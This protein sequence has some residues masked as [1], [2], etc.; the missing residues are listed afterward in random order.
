MPYRR[1]GGLFGTR[2]RRSTR[3]EEIH[4]SSERGTR[5]RARRVAL[6]RPGPKLEIGPAA[7]RAGGEAA[8]GGTAAAA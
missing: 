1:R 4:L 2:R 6:E 8:R 3:E 7:S 5:F